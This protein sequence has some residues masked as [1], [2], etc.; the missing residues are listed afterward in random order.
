MSKEDRMKMTKSS[1]L[2]REGA[3][4][5]SGFNGKLMRIS[6]KRA[7]IEKSSF[8]IQSC[9]PMMG[10][11][12]FYKMSPRTRCTADQ[13][14]PWFPI[15]DSGRTIAVGLIIQGQLAFN[16]RT[17]KNWFEKPYRA[18]VK[19]VITSGPQCYYDA[20]DSPGVVALH[21]Y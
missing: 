6:E 19:V 3:V 21:I 13:L 1:S 7:D 12:F 11:H 10:R 8:T 17:K 5:V 18:D 4:W 14:L 2:L 20:A 15:A 16:K 9:I